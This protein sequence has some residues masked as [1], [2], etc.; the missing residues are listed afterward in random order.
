MSQEVWLIVVIALP[1]LF[2]AAELIARSWIR[3]RARYFCWPP[4]T[5]FR[6]PLDRTV[7]ASGDAE[8]RFDVNR[9]GERGDAPPHSFDGVY[10][11]L[12][13]G[14]SA[15][16]C[17]YLDQDSSWPGR[18]QQLLSRPEACQRLDVRAAHVG[19]IARSLVPCR[20]IRYQLEK[21]LPQLPHSDAALL[22]VGA[23][24]LVTWLEQH[25]PAQIDPGGYALDSI[26]GLHPERS[27]G[28]KPGQLALR[29]AAASALRALLR[30]VERRETSG[31]RLAA[32]RAMRAGARQ[33]LEDIADPA[34]MLQ[35]YEADLREVLRALMR[36]SKRVVVVQQM[37]L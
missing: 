18:L 22:M 19:N 20:A 27:F 31:K 12:V 25:T 36:H 1:L 8:V 7:F 9:L 11:V 32:N 13:A 23:S 16:E 5:R 28:W 6:M 17:Y 3:S 15:A 26:F 33:I 24:D 4:H 34:P 37:W 2:A 14:G 35:R 29:R 10:R 21:L 30:P